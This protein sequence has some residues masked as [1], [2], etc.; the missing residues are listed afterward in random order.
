MRGERLPARMHLAGDH[1][2]PTPRRGRCRIRIFVP[3]EEG[4]RLGDRP[5]VICSE[6]EGNPG[7]GSRRRRK[8]SGGRSRRRFVWATPCG[9]NTI[10]QRPPTAT[11]RLSSWSFDRPSADPPGSRWTGPRSRGWW[12]GGRERATAGGPGGHARIARNSCVVSC[13]KV[14]WIKRA[15][16]GNGRAP[17]GSRLR[18]VR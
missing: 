11:R 2:Q 13:T 1:V 15:S 10:P 16:L 3:D 9:S 14:E 8:R 4:E 5:V 17:K 12:A 6:V 18:E 7:A